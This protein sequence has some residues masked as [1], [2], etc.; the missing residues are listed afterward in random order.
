MSD[1]VSDATVDANATPDARVMLDT[2]LKPDAAVP[3]TDGSPPGTTGQQPSRRRGGR[4]LRLALLVTGLSLILVV[5]GT[6]AAGWLYAR[7][8]ESHVDK[9]EIFTALP[10]AQRPVKA[11]EQARNFLI[12][13]SDSRDPDTSGSRTD[14]IILAHLPADRGGVQMISIPRDTWVRVPDPDGGDGRQDKINSAYATGGTPLLVQTVEGFTGVRIDHVVLIDFAG[15]AEIIDAVGGIELAVDESFT[16]V[17]PP[18]RQFTAGLQQMDGD[19]ALDY[20]RQ[21][22]QFADGDFTRVRHQQEIIA[23]VLDQASGSGLLTSPGRLDDF[24]RATA[25]AVTVDEGTSVFDT[26]WALRQLRST[27]LTMLT[28]PSAGTGQQAG[29]S[30]VFP[31]DAAAADLYAAVRGDTVDDWLREHPTGR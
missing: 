3:E 26:V 5:G 7:S 12:V 25:D 13:G 6:A 4:W 30:V 14:T 27:D 8:V 18:Y 24:L 31:D 9:V 21:R 22:K 11:V 2:N 16:S 19:T 28:S 15:F 20:A 17:H 1:A 23:A 29:Q 10:E